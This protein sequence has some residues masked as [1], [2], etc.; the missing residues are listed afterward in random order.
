L[1]R[2]HAEG[3]HESCLDHVSFAERTL[4]LSRLSASLIWLILSRGTPSRPPVLMH[5]SNLYPLVTVIRPGSKLTRA[6]LLGSERFLIAPNRAVPVSRVTDSARPPPEELVN[7]ASILITLVRGAAPTSLA[8][9]FPQS[10]GRIL[11]MNRC[12]LLIAETPCPS[13]VRL[14]LCPAFRRL[15]L[16]RPSFPKA[17]RAARPC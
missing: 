16:G 4:C 14:S 9:A 15:S 6:T 10:P 11:E 5:S 8:P 7:T 2:R 1:Y 3:F 13:R 12:H 17:A